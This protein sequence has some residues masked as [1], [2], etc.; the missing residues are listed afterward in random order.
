MGHGDLLLLTG[1]EVAGLLSDREPDV[2]DAVRAAYVAHA[3]GETVVPHST[4]LLFPG[5]PS[6]RIIGLPAYIGGPFQA[7]GMKWV[8]SFPGNVAQGGRRA[9]AVVVLNSMESGAPTAFLE[10]SV[11]NAKRTAAS[12]ALA[13]RHLHGP[14]PSRLG[15]VGCGVI[16]FEIARFLC[17]VLP[18]PRDFVVHDTDLERAERFAERVRALPGAAATT[19]ADLGTVLCESGLVTFA[20]TAAVPHVADLSACPA[21]TTILH[22][23]LRDLDPAVILDADNVVDDVDHVCRA[24]TSV[25]LAEQRR[26]DRSFVR[27]TLGD[28]LLG[29]QPGR[30]GHGA[31]TIFSPFGLGILDVAVSTLVVRLAR[32]AGVGRLI[33]DFLPGV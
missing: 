30:N 9:A 33:G 4:F 10:G 15:M 21:G 5:R 12:A 25:H 22:V 23:S 32:E 19:A 20:T 11:V 7:A 18:E 8:S 6:D 13:A 17:A 14:S 3:R 28:V 29:R 27:C 2:L 26:G 24:Q 1:D 31:V 16:A